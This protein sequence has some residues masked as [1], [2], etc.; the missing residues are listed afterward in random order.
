[1]SSLRIKSSALIELFNMMILCMLIITY[2]I[3][4]I[5]RIELCVQ[6]LQQMVVG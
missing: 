5:F 1:M 6:E 3:I 2:L 4:E